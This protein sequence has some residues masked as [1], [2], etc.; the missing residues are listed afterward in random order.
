MEVHKKE[1]KVIALKM[2]FKQLDVFLDLEGNFLPLLC[3]R[4]F[5]FN[6]FNIVFQYCTGRMIKTSKA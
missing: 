6:L 5:L 3:L 1:K 2:S 4:F